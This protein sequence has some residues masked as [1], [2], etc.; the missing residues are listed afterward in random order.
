[1][2]LQFAFC[3][4]SILVNQVSEVAAHWDYFSTY[5]EQMSH[6]KH[7]FCCVRITNVTQEEAAARLQ[8]EM[9]D[10]QQQLSNERNLVVEAQSIISTTQVLCFPILC[11]HIF[12]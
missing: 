11:S 8:Q 10:L 7:N 2:V 12:V 6:G 3:M 1:M 9:G 4:C 5:T